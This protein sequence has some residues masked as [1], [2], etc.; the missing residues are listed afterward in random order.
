MTRS[1]QGGAQALLLEIYGRLRAAHG[2]PR[3][4][5]ANSPYEVM[6]GAILTQNT[7]WGNVEKAIANF[8]DRLSEEFVLGLDHQVLAEIIRPSGFYSQKA[9]YLQTVTRWYGKY[10]YRVDTVRSLPMAQIR[11]ELLALRGVGK[12]TADAIL[13][14]AFDFP[15]FVVDAYTVR[16]VERLPLPMPSPLTKQ[17]GKNYDAIKTFFELHLPSDAKLFNEYHALIV[18]HAKAH[19]RKRPQCSGCPLESMCEKNV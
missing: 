16:L 12:E 10:G 11:E 19:C 14:Y 18:L 5:P 9:Q 4:W 17:S 3:W 1:G 13:L 15:S 6:V 8:A 2:D 7:A